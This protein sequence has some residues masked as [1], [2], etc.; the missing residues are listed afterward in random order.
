MIAVLAGKSGAG[1]TTVAKRLEEMFGI[2]RVVTYTTRP[3]RKGEVD[4]VDYCFVDK[5]SFFLMEMNNE[6]M[7]SQDYHASFGKVSYGSSKLDFRLEYLKEEDKNRSI[8][9]NPDGVLNVLEKYEFEKSFVKFDDIEIFYLDVPD[10]VLKKRLENRGDD[11]E[12]ISRR[13]SSDAQDLEKIKPLVEEGRIHVL[14]G[15]DDVDSICKK[16]KEYVKD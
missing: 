14:N 13:M 15:E 9:L 8:V 2:K 5:W 16:I 10:L 1:K 7:E 3:P 4:G 6:L 11:A 12:E